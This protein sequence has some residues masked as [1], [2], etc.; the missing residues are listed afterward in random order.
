VVSGPTGQPVDA[1]FAV[2]G[3]TATIELAE[4][5]A[6]PGRFEHTH[7][8]SRGAGELLRA[9]LGTNCDEIVIGLGSSV[10]TDGGAGMLQAL[11][12]RVL[13]RL[14]QD[15]G[16][17]GTALEAVLAVDLDGLDPR[18]REVGIVLAG[19]LDTPLFGPRGAAAVHGQRRGASAE[20]VTRLDRA[21]MCW[22]RVLAEVT[23][24]DMSGRPGAG[25]AGGVGFAALAV[26]GATTRL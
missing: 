23:G 1:V 18:V 15:L 3:G 19:D 4:P 5:R 2:G 11:G 20:E 26:L 13:D 24:T 9:A 16:P 22:A 8:S 6:R 25:G 10:S 17:G 7:A 14:G 12:A 21:L